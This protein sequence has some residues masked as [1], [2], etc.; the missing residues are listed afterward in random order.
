[1]VKLH[2]KVFGLSNDNSAGHSER[3]KKT[4][5]RSFASSNRAADDRTRWNGIVV[6]LSVVPQRK[7]MG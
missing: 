5:L 7:A 4:I 3:K 6:K 1:M 2:L